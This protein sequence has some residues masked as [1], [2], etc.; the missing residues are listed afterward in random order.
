M[1]VS[2]ARET[3]GNALIAHANSAAHAPAVRKKCNTKNSW[4]VD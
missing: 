4:I 3:T 1:A 2:A